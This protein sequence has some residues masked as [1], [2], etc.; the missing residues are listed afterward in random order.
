MEILILLLLICP[1]ASAKVAE[2][3]GRN[4]FGWAVAGLLLGPVGLLAACGAGD[5]IQQNALLKLLKAEHEDD[6]LV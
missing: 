2:S 4:S 3:K 1:V 5:K 6:S